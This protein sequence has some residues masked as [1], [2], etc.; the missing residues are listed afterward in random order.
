MNPLYS[1]LIVFLI[2]SLISFLHLILPFEM[3]NGQ[4]EHLYVPLSPD[5]RLHI[6]NIESKLDIPSH[7]FLIL[8]SQPLWTIELRASSHISIEL[9]RYMCVAILYSSTKGSFVK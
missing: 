1:L 2:T 9:N 6:V 3:L 7:C 5:R 8:S 4:E